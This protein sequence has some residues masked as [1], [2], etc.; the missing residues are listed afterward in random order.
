M[1]W[2]GFKMTWIG[3]KM[4]W[5]GFKMQIKIGNNNGRMIFPHPWTWQLMMENQRI[6]YLKNCKE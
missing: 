5:I 3:F 1:T 2:I 4:T 6:K